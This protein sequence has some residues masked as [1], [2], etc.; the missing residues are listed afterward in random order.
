[1]SNSPATINETTI[2]IA[3]NL[4]TQEADTGGNVNK[5]NEIEDNSSLLTQLEETTKELVDAKNLLKSAEEN[6]QQEREQL[7]ETLDQN[8]LQY[9][10]DTEQLKEQLSTEKNEQIKRSMIKT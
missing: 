2:P 8:T 4:S 6:F 3:D 10:Q 7:R 1:M 9:Q 5:P